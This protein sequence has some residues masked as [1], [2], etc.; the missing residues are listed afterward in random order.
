MPCSLMDF[1]EKILISINF[2]DFFAPP[3]G[4]FEE[5]KPLVVNVLAVFGYAKI[6]DVWHDCQRKRQY[7]LV[8]YNYQ[9]YMSTF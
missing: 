6:S 7:Y 4:I 9:Q 1:L 3:M 8:L 5:G 2:I